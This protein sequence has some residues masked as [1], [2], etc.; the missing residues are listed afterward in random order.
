MHLETLVNFSM[1]A[2]ELAINVSVLK[3]VQLSAKKTS[4]SLFLLTTAKI[5]PFATLEV[6]NSASFPV[7]ARYLLI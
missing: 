5:N 3:S 6:I 4:Q 2:K 1:L 7:D